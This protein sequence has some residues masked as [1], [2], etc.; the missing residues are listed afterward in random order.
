MNEDRV[1]HSMVFIRIAVL[2]LIFV[3][4]WLEGRFGKRKDIACATWAWGLLALTAW[5]AYPLTAF[6]I[7]IGVVVLLSALASMRV[8]YRSGKSR[9]ETL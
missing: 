9:R 7:S 8:Y 3:A 6:R 2:G 1:K 4:G 5:I